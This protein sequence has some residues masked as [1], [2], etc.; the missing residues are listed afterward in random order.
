MQKAKDLFKNSGKKYLSK[1]DI[2]NNIFVK[3]EE[4]IHLNFM[5]LII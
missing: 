2:I 4:E 5:F 1:A 3:E